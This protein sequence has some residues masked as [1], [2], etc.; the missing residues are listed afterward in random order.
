MPRHHRIRSL[1]EPLEA[2]AMAK[3][4]RDIW[5]FEIPSQRDLGTQYP[6]EK[7]FSKDN[8]AFMPFDDFS[9]DEQKD[10][11]N[12][13]TLNFLLQYLGYFSQSSKYGLQFYLGEAIKIVKAKP[14]KKRASQKAVY[15]AT[16]QPEFEKWVKEFLAGRKQ[17]KSNRFATSIQVFRH[18]AKV[19][20]LTLL[21]VF[22]F[23]LSK[24]TVVVELFFPDLEEIVDHPALDDI[25]E[26]LS[27][28]MS[29]FG[30]KKVSAGIFMADLRVNEFLQFLPFVD[31]SLFPRV[32]SLKQPVFNYL[33]NQFLFLDRVREP[34]YTLE[35]IEDIV[36]EFPRAD[37]ELRERVY[38]ELLMFITELRL[39]LFAN[40]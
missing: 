36:T 29:A 2:Y 38:L 19:P 33:W 9:N 35:N 30:K 11:L 27:Q 3:R 1:K 15:K 26:I 12:E 8:E 40:T 24:D 7:E 31:Q 18:D 37:V 39:Y 6:T 34:Q 13:L 10:V 25:A 16:I 4:D 28:F 14:S 23:E 5:N 22:Y 21:A 17:H 32:K 20:E